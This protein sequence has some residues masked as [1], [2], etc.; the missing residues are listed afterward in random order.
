[1]CRPN[2]GKPVQGSPRRK[3]SLL[4]TTESFRCN[5]FV[6]KKDDDDRSEWVGAPTV[7]STLM[8]V[9][10]IVVAFFGIEHGL[11]YVFQAL[12]HSHYLLENETN[13]HVLS[14]HIGVD[15]LACLAVGYVGIK[16][17]HIMDDLKN[18]T[19]RRSK[20]MVETDY[21]KRLFTYHPAAQ[22]VL[23]LFFSY[24]VKNMYDTIVWN[25]GIIFIIHHLLSGA[26]AWGGMYP[27]AAHFYAIF[28]MGISEISTAILCL[29]ANFDDEFGVVGLGDAFPITRAALGVIFAVAFIICRATIWPI[30]T[31]HLFK[32]SIQALKSESSKYR[33]KDKWIKIFMFTSSALSILQVLWL[34]EI[35]VTVK[36]EVEKLLV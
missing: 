9:A 1:M 13:R 21:E 7:G 5:D 17:L 20:S 19:L 29:L 27:G 18:H 36:T 30:V 28:Y 25:D 8:T 10:A 6:F 34:G 33:S 14:R 32:D 22:Q 11:R 35:I 2:R 26:A 24:Q 15:A 16:N 4:L 12:K 23:L 3:H 31:Y